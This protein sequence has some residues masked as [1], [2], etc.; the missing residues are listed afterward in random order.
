[1]ENKE[2]L[3]RAYKEKIEVL[4]LSMEVPVEKYADALLKYFNNMREEKSIL[5]I[6]NYYGS[7]KITLHI[8]L[9]NYLKSDS[10]DERAES[11]EHLKDWFRGDL[12]I[13][14]KDIEVEFYEGYVFYINEFDNEKN[15]QSFKDDKWIM[16]YLILEDY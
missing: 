5:K 3:L 2:T 1:M 12:D 7:N 13:S 14:T 9:T 4:S 6:Q 8:N 16:N 11:I 10:E 15:I